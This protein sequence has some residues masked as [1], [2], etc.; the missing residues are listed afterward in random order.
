MRDA[1]LNEFAPNRFGD[2]RRQ[3]LDFSFGE[4]L[5]HHIFNPR[6]VIDGVAIGFNT[7]GG[8]HIALARHEQAD[9]LAI[10]GINA[11]TAL[12]AT[13]NSAAR[14]ITSRRSGDIAT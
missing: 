8:M 1:A 6:G 9:Q 11:G 4:N 10:N 14:S 2:V 7:R 13:P 5:A 3:A 12:A